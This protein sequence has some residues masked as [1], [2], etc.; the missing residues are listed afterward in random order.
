MHAGKNFSFKEVVLWTRRDI[1]VLL[2]ISFVPTFCYEVLG[3]KW[4]AI[5]WLPIALLGTA[6]AFIVGFKNNAS[7]DRMWEARRVWGS[8]VNASRS[9]GI[10]V[11]DYIS[12]TN[13]PRQY[14]DEEI[15]KFQY[16]LLNYHFAWLAALRFALREKRVWE[17]INKPHNTEYRNKWFKVAEHNSKLEHELQKYLSEDDIQRILSKS[18]KASYIMGL[19]S[20][21]LK[22]LREL[23]LIDDF[24]HVELEKMLTEFLTQQGASERIKNFPYPRQYA[25]LNLYFI[26]IFVFL[27]PLGMLQEFAKL[28]GC[29]IWFAVPFSALSSWIFT[30]LEKIGE[31]TESPFEGS[32][33]DVPITA[34][35]RTIEID[36]REMFDQTDIPEAIHPENNILI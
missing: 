22:E 17:G 18:N 19:Q 10:M 5:P 26:R 12:N 28:G 8:I 6:V 20:A 13:A 33:N 21:H 27:V 7:Y 34:I 23:G 4:L 31:A 24:R 15:R 25:T 35:S 2:L 29:M 14:S 11:K 9:W 16:K 3:Y 36:L 30:T 1:Y 32:A